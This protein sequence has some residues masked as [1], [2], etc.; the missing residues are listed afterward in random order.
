MKIARLDSFRY[1]C[2]D[3]KLKAKDKS[4]VALDGDNFSNEI[5]G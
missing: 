1:K 4:S 2:F 5:I 3:R